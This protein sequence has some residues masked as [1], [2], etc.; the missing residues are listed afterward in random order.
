MGMLIDGKWDANATRA[1]DKDGRFM[2]K[3]SIFRRWVTADGS[4]GFK[5][6]PGRYHLYISYNCP[7]AHRTAIFRKLKGLEG[8]IGLSA[9][10]PDESK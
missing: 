8:A 6:E 7:W 10:V 3:D 5:A 2:R 1:A 9:E 4:S